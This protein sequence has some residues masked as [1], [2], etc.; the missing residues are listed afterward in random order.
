MRAAV[1]YL[2]RGAVAERGSRR[3]PAESAI[4]LVS[5]CRTAQRK[6]NSRFILQESGSVKAAALLKSKGAITKP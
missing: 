6:T 3:I 5:R 1:A 4:S 2:D